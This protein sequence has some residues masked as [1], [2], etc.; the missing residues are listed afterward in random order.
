MSVLL[1]FEMQEVS[2]VLLLRANFLS[3]ALLFGSLTVSVPSATIYALKS[4]N[5]K[6]SLKSLKSL[7]SQKSD[8]SINVLSLIYLLSLYLSTEL[9]D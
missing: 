4:Q 2:G 1:I 3:Y 7:K 5:H 6:K 8:L 9:T